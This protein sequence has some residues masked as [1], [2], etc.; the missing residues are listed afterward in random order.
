MTV[1]CLP[2]AN[3]A[4]FAEPV[5]TFPLDSARYRN[6]HPTLGRWIQRDPAGYADGAN[7][8]QYAGAAPLSHGDPSGLYNRPQHERDAL[9]QAHDAGFCDQAARD[10]ARADQ[11]WDEHGR[12]AFTQG[13]FSFLGVGL[14]FG[15][16][17]TYQ[18]HFPGAGPPLLG[19]P[20]N[21]VVPGLGNAY[22][23][24]LLDQATDS[25]ELEDIGRA[26]HAL[27]DS[28]AHAGQ[29]T[30]GGHPFGR[31]LINPRTGAVESSGL[32]DWRL[33]EPQWDP[34]RYAACQEDVAEALDDIYDACICILCPYG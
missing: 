15:S 30:L 34:E 17:E 23:Q 20:Q 11:D 2:I 9:Q 32:G 10:I 4:L 7:L 14:I 22:V 31:R 27:Q 5:R 12:D 1:S 28:Y 24:D 16:G 21:P 6:Y 29:P 25:C 18:T 3:S 13:L 8:H 19:V 26:L 33:D